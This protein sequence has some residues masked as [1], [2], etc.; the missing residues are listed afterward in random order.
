MGAFT[1]SAGFHTGASGLNGMG[2]SVRIQP[3]DHV[4]FSCSVNV[5][6]KWYVQL[7]RKESNKSIH[8]ISRSLS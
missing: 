2:R 8:P 7:N 5:R 4:L 6:Q 3:V 1:K